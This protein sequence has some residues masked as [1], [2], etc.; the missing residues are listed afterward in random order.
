VAGLRAVPPGER[1]PVNLV[2]QTYH[3]M[4]ALGMALLALSWLGLFLWWRRRLFETRWFLWLL[5]FAVLGPQLAN[6]AG[7]ASAEVGRQPYIV[8]GLLRTADALSPVVGAGEVLTS[9]ILFGLVYLLLF[10]LF[11]YLLNEKIQHG[12]VDDETAGEGQRA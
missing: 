9:I 11:V 10:V 8:Q 3:L 6:Q 4:V 5:V 12:P 1:P 7:W 2:F